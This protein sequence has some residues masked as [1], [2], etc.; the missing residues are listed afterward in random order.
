MD[1][2][3]FDYRAFSQAFVAQKERKRRQ[4]E[5]EIAASQARILAWR[6]AYKEKFNETARDTL[7]QQL[8]SF[9]VPRGDLRGNDFQGALPLGYLFGGI[10]DDDK[11]LVQVVEKFTSKIGK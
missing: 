3:W 8:T 11:F 5:Q 10:V 1:E 9:T 7:Q 6:K 4:K 2:G